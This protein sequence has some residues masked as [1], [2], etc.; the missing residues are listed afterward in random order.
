MLEQRTRLEPIQEESER[1]D[2]T[3]GSKTGEGE[4]QEEEEEEEETTTTQ[5]IADDE[6][7]GDED[8]PLRVMRPSRTYHSLSQQSFLH[9]Q[10]SENDGEEMVGLWESDQS[11]HLDPPGEESPPLQR[12]RLGIEKLSTSVK[13][14]RLKVSKRKMNTSDQ[15]AKKK[16]REVKKKKKK[17]KRSLDNTS[18]EEPFPGWLVDLMVNIEEATTHQL[19]VE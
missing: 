13:R 11:T 4:E 19:V 2:E 8:A 15:S 14:E 6:S 18:K 3:T 10:P 17:K 16:K 9:T 12:T 5:E 7:E 1:E